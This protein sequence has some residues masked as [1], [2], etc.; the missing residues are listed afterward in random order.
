[1]S[2][3]KTVRRARTQDAEAPITRRGRVAVPAEPKAD[4]AP[5][6]APETS[7]EVEMVT[8][9]VPKAFHLTL[10]HHRSVTYEPGTQDMPRDHAEHWFAKAH[11]VE[12]YGG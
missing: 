12:I 8:A 1:M 5:E 7:D 11:G 6:Q 10:D 4:E 2:D 9:I 3:N